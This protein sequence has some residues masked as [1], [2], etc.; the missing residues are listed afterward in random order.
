[1][2]ASATLTLI[3]FA[4]LT[5]ACGYSGRH[6]VIA[7]K[8]PGRDLRI[9]YRGNIYFNKEGTAIE[10]ITPNGYA[11][12]NLNGNEMIAESDGYGQITYQ[13]NNHGLEKT[14]DN[15]EKDFVAMAVR[16]MI[17]HSQYARRN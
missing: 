12:Y 2:K 1:M 17:K 13:I 8:A 14:L 4:L 9:E 6:T 16:D 15:N 7:E 10:R 11:K 5:A 3:I